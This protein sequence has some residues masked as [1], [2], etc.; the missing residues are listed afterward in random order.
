MKFYVRP[1]HEVHLHCHAYRLSWHMYKNHIKTM[2]Q[3]EHEFMRLFNGAR[4][5]HMP[6]YN[7]SL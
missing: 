4:I 2:Q 5:A 1:A 6:S 3:F 7:S